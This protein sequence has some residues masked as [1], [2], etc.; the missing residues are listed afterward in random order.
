MRVG[1]RAANAANLVK[2]LLTVWDETNQQIAKFGDRVMRM[3]AAAIQ[4]GVTW[5]TV[6]NTGMQENTVTLRNANNH[7][8][9]WG[10]WRAALTAVFDFVRVNGGFVDATFDIYDGDNKVGEGEIK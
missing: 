2:M 6:A 5:Q 9:T 7:Q 4:E 3:S 10:V 1:W 8:V